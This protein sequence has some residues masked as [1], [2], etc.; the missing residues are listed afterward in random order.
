MNNYILALQE[1]PGK[2]SDEWQAVSVCW[3][4]LIPLFLISGFLLI[5]VSGNEEPLFTSILIPINAAPIDKKM[6]LRNSSFKNII[7]TPS[8]FFVTL[9]H[10]LT[11]ITP[12]QWN[13]L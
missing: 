2:P 3:A 4:Q 9:C 8:V 10:S 7:L 11:L 1:H 6:I 12:R 13:K 5:W